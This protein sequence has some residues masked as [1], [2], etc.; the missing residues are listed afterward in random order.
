VLTI[1]SGGGAL[2]FIDIRKQQ[3][4]QPS[5]SHKTLKISHGPSVRMLFYIAN[6][7]TQLTDLSRAASL[8]SGVCLVA[9]NGH[10]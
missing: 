10:C 3:L 8:D 2:V 5:P 1:G 9:T 4:I 6:V 7:D